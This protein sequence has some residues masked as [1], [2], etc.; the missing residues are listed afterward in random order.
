LFNNLHLERPIV[1]IDVETTGLNPQTDRI[2][3]LSLLKVYPDGTEEYK[4]HR[5]NPCMPIPSAAMAIHG[6]KDADVAAEPTFVQYAKGIKEFLDGCDIAGFNVIK[7][8]LPFIEAE[9]NRTKV[10]FSR[11]GRYLV[12]SQV[13]YH[14]REPRDLVSAYRKYCGKELEHNHSA[15][16]DAKASAEVLD[17]QLE[18]YKDLPRK[19]SDLCGL[20][21]ETNENYIDA[22]GK[23]IWVEGE[24]VCNFGSK[25][26][27]RKLC[28]IL[29]QDPSYLRWIAGA[30][31][32][33]DVRQ[34][35]FKALQGE[36]PMIV[37]QR[38]EP[39]T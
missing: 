8:D 34:M 20:C 7:F 11:Q 24:A 2:V 22:E 1:F 15:Q 28:D 19:V 3:E 36:L 16:N 21:Y 4:N 10:E 17:G 27:G 30:D 39:N 33:A 23:F 29:A 12:D 26:K 13:I 32:A 35:A 6:I 25:H 18:A 5:I 14:K 9:M 31:F 37:R 38:T